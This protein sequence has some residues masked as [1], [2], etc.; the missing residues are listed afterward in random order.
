VEINPGKS[1]EIIHVRVRVIPRANKDQ[2][3]GFMQDGRLKVRLTAPPVEG[4][5]NQALVKFISDTLGIQRGQ[6]S[7]TSGTSSR[8][9][10]L[11]IRGMSMKEFQAHIKDQK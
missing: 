9:K 8:N 10:T 1:D 11:E 2:I 6:I 5:A 3:S 4:K 7:I